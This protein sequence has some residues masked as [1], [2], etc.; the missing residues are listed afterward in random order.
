MV[1]VRRS[2]EKVPLIS[3]H[4]GQQFQFS[5]RGTILTEVLGETQ[6]PPHCP[7]PAMSPL[8]GGGVRGEGPASL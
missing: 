5:L 1:I 2:G 6:H 8:G 3:T 7:L 4:L